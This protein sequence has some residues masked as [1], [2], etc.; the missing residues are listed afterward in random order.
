MSSERTKRR[1]SLWRKARELTRGDDDR[2]LDIGIALRVVRQDIGRGVEAIP[3]APPLVA[4]AVH[5]QRLG[6]RYDTSLGAF[7]GPAESHLVWYIGERQSQI[8]LRRDPSK[9]RTLLYSA[10]GGG[11]TV[12]MAQW[13]VLQVL[14]LAQ[15]GEP[16]FV[17][18]TAPTQKRLK[19][20]RD[21]VMDI[22]P[23]DHAKARRAGSWATWFQDD[24]EL[25][26]A[27]GH[28]LQFRA[29]KKQSGATGSPIQ[30][31][32]WKASG[33]DELQD[34][35]ENGADPDI[36]ARLRGARVS[37][38]MCTAT[39]KDSP[40]WRTFRDSKLSTPDWSLERIRYDETPFVWPEHWEKMQR[41]VSL[42]EWQRRGLAMD[43]GPE[44]MVYHT[45]DRAKN[46]IPI[47][48]I[49]AEDV[50]AEVLRPWGP[51]HT[52]LVGHDPGKLFDVSVL[53]KAYRLRGQQ[54]HVWWVV[55]EVTTEQS[56]T[57]MHVAELLKTLRSPPLGCNQKDWRG[58][59]AVSGPSALV[60]VDPYSTTGEDEKHP[61]RTVYTI[62]RAAG[63][64]ALPGA[65]TPAVNAVKVGRVP[66]DA[67]IQVV[68]GLLCDLHDKRHLFVNCDDRR[69]PVA[70]RLVESIELSERDEAG[71]AEAQKKNKR[72]L[73]HWTAA[74]RYALW[75]LEKPRLPRYEA[76]A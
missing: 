58:R 28:V 72:D 16:G 54:R 69:I 43:V 8:L 36:E 6:G 64:Q 47:P 71:K 63:L 45:W 41:N 61:D 66:K 52:V 34:T 55:G 44:R 39:A 67:G 15:A 7:V 57:E 74:L 22:I 17:G 14:I 12:L 18:A 31:Y 49:G 62:F 56:T 1:N 35:V 70:P 11:K 21:A 68:V 60:R 27:T 46:L 42:R 51:N 48:Q 9:S 13:L 5:P 30:G 38:R 26:F 76:S 65:T 23:C 75:V 25:R 50:T 40:N 29:T 24:Q 33:D 32:T 53:L 73:S 10:E 3:G 2:F 20:L 59:D 19:S 4:L 37:Y